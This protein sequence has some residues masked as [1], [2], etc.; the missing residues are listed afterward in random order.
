MVLM[1]KTIHTLGDFPCFIRTPIYPIRKLQLASTTVTSNWANKMLQKITPPPSLMGV[2]RFHNTSI[3]L[4]FRYNGL[5]KGPRRTK[6]TTGADFFPKFAP[7]SHNG[8]F[9]IESRKTIC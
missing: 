3:F 8:Q 7:P 4:P 2:V 1:D 9:Y 6:T 5:R